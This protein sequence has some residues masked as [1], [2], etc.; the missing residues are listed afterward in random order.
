MSETLAFDFYGEHAASKHQHDEGVE[1][2]GVDFADCFE[3]AKAHAWL[4][5]EQ[6]DAI[7]VEIRDSETTETLAV[8]YADG[9][10]EV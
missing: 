3:Q 2:T 7:R 5:W 1:F 6:W 10:K 9:I 4:L 8:V